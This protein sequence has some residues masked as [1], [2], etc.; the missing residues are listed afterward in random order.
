MLKA[1]TQ[2][3]KLCDMDYDGGTNCIVF[4][5]E[6]SERRREIDKIEY[7]AHRLRCECKSGAGVYIDE[8]AFAV[9]RVIGAWQRRRG[10]DT[11]AGL[12]QN[13]KEC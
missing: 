6:T 12:L 9:K 2:H 8:G 13:S 4:L 7:R 3:H 11:H 1:M 5:R 10:I